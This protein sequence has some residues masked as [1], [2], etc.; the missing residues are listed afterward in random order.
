ML[1]NGEIVLEKFLLKRPPARSFVHG[2]GPRERTARRDAASETN[3]YPQACRWQARFEIENY[4]TAELW[5]HT[6]WQKRILMLRRC[7]AEIVRTRLQN[8]SR[9]NEVDRTVLCSRRQ[10][11]L[12]KN[13]DPAAFFSRSSVFCSGNLKPRFWCLTLPVR[14]S[15][16]LFLF[17]RFGKVRLAESL[18][19][20]AT[21]IF[22]TLQNVN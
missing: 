5:T 9:R 4:K 11:E 3:I 22:G 7:Y 20:V 16:A 21:S 8:H 12:H 1:P 13:L 10:D 18:Q 14:P 17:G 15:V 19:K 2:S 6:V